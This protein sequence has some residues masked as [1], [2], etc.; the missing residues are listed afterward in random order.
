MFTVREKNWHCSYKD[1]INEAKT[2]CAYIV[3]QLGHEQN[4]GL[5]F[6]HTLTHAGTGDVTGK[7]YCSRC[8]TLHIQLEYKTFVLNLSFPT[9]KLIAKE[10]GEL[11]F[12]SLVCGGNQTKYSVS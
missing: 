1:D 10:I 4:N 11:Y 9:L 7:L 2:T 3:V 8:Y 5:F 12:L 6:T